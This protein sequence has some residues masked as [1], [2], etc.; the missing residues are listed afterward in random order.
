MCLKLTFFLLSIAVAYAVLW[1]DKKLCEG[2]SNCYCEQDATLLYLNC[3]A[4]GVGIHG[5]NDGAILSIEC[6]ESEVSPYDKF[7]KLHLDNMSM[8]RSLELA[9]C[10]ILADD[11]VVL[12]L[13]HFGI[14][15]FNKRQASAVLSL[16]LIFNQLTN[17]HDGLF[18]EFEQ[19]VNLRLSY[20]NL[21]RILG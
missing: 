4:M 18:D 20:N 9:A 17:L 2:I 12:V 11:S 14:E 10:P 5:A 21:S 19:L 13:G 7:P 16:D 15:L 3:S 8:F 1:H 6:Y